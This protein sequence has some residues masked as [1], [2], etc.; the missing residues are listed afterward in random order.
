MTLLRGQKFT[1][2]GHRWR[3]VSVSESRAHCVATVREP[4]TVNDR[5]TGDTRTFQATRKI[6]ID[7]S[8]NSAVEM[9]AEKAS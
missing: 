2:G 1:M 7:I 4:V 8:P 6:T 5:K 9:L 3:V